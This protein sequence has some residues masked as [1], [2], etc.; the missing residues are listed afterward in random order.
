[1]SIAIMATG[2][3]DS[4]LLMY[5]YAWADP[6]LLSVNYGQT[7]WDYQKE[8]IEYHREKSNIS[9]ELVEIP[10]TYHDWQKT[11]GLFQNGFVP[12]DVNPLESWDDISHKSYFVEGRNSI[13]LCYA[14]A[15]CSHFGIDEMLVGYEYE[16]DEWQNIRTTKMVS[17]DTSP[18]FLDT[19][20]ILAMSGF[21]RVVRI[22]APF[23]EKR[24][25]KVQIMH[26]CVIEGIDLDKT[27]SCYFWP[28][29]C[30][31]CDNCLLRNKFYEKRVVG[32]PALPRKIG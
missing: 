2:G 21:S 7:I 18:H 9:H 12:D 8:L 11:P 15:Y 13:M 5:K 30:G 23:Y 10:V 25:D 19:M 32:I 1:M 3:T 20:N 27:Y 22:R 16:T 14:L 4:T 17:D 28:G 24:M 26:E 31:K 29:P 6:I